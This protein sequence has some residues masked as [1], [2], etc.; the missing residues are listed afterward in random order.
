MLDKN[1]RDLG[2]WLK[3]QGF[4]ENDYKKW[5]RYELDARDAMFEA[6][7]KSGSPREILAF[8]KDA[9]GMPYVPG[10]HFKRDDSHGTAC[11]GMWNE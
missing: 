2:K 1:A 7:G 4:S 8:I 3:E 9:Y 11:L 5:S 6:Q 10:E